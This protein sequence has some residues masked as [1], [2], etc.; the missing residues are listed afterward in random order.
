M[1]VKG[2]VYTFT[3]RG[4]A[5]AA[6]TTYFVVIDRV[7]ATSG[8][9]LLLTL[10]G[11]VRM[12]MRERTSYCHRAA[13]R[14]YGI[15]SAVLICG[16]V[17][18]EAA[19]QPTWCGGHSIEW[20]GGP[21]RA[22]SALADGSSSA[23]AIEQ[24]AWLVRDRWDAL[25]FNAF[26]NPSPEGRLTEVLARGDVSSIRVCMQSPE[27]SEV[28]Q[29]L[30]PYSD[31]SWWRFH[32]R[33]WTGVS[34]NGEIVIADCTGEPARSW[35]QVR[36]AQGNEISTAHTAFTTTRRDGEGG[37]VS[38]ELVFQPE[39]PNPEAWEPLVI[40]GILAHELGHAMGFSHVSGAFPPWIMIAPAARP[41]PEDESQHAQLA[42]QVGPNVPYPGLTPPS[43]L[44][45]DATLS[46][47]D[48]TGMIGSEMTGS[49]NRFVYP[50]ELGPVFD[51]AIQ[52]YTATAPNRVTSVT[53]QA[54]VNEPNATVTVN[55]AAVLLRGTE[56]DAIELAVGENIFEVVVTAQDGV[57][58][59]TY[60]VTVTRAALP[61]T[62]TLSAA[63]DP[64]E[65]GPAVTVT[66]TLDNPAP[67]NGITVTLTTSGTA[68]LDTDYTLSSTTITLAAGE[69]AIT[70]TVTVT[71]DAE[72]DDGET[73][74]IDA[75][76]T[77]PAL[78]AEPL[79]L[80]IEDNDGPA[81][82]LLTLSAAS[83]PIEGGHPVTVTATLD[84]PAPA[85]GLTVTLTTGG[86]ATLDTDY[87]LSS[88]TITLAAGET[89]GTVTITVTDDAED[90]A[91]ETIV[92]DAEST[93]PA[94]TAEPLTLTIEDNDVTPVP[95]L[96]LGGAMLLGL[97]LTLLGAVRMRMR[98]RTDIARGC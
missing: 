37:W 4:I 85:T 55:G 77:S 91:G 83:A 64:A 88:T 46:T 57:T 26:E 86:T 67:A 23:L 42:Y 21:P 71:D 24:P 7:G 59:L 78:T 13:R 49:D 18:T 65:G 63:P 52:S 72:D 25:V 6:S 19:A 74:V 43:S 80:T 1:R 58:M 32:I 98:E 11:A 76:S 35:I 14:R 84:N 12:R 94:L 68:T 60:T 47:L 75:E 79:T 96:P 87:T 66:A 73:I 97:L 27:T 89:A 17:A 28:G 51:S 34:W 22:F 93:S 54:R 38:S 92:L 48:L 10:L 29:L 56:S 5:L 8:S 61:T 31:A 39:P 90:D 50:L 36:A 95:A 2:R 41:W 9:Q 45:N 69:T 70:V 82:T 81:P 44:S 33:R 20:A 15:C 16:L 40:E 62:L 53:V 30:E 3:T